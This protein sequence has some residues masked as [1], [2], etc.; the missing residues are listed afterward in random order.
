MLISFLGAKDGGL[1]AGLAEFTNDGRFLRRIDQP[2]EAPYGYDVAVKPERNRMVTSSF[3]A[4]RNY[5]KPLANMDLKDFG[6]QMVV[7]DFKAR[8]P[9]QVGLPGRRRTVSTRSS[10]PSRASAGLTRS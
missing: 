2:A 4:R 9:I 3:T 7:W 8:R 1:P 5:S 10:R 6:N